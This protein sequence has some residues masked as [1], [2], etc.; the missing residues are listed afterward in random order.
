MGSLMRK[1]A[2]GAGTGLAIAGQMGFQAKLA[3]DLDSHRAEMMARRDAFLGVQ[4]DARLDKRIGAEQGEGVL[5]REH[6]TNLATVQGRSAAEVKRLDN[7]GDIAKLE[8]A[9][10]LKANEP[11]MADGVAYL[12]D[13][14][15]R[16]IPATK[17]GEEWTANADLGVLV[18][19]GTGKTKPVGDG[20]GGAGGTKA[21]EASMKR[22]TM[23]KDLAKS[24]MGV[25]FFQKLNDDERKQFDAIFVEAARNSRTMPNIEDAYEAAIEKWNKRK[26]RAGVTGDSKP[27]GNTDSILDRFGVPKAR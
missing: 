7:E 23:L 12:K 15:G 6:A 18:E 17:K 21:E 26:A 8:R 19:K 1:M 5:N 10:E 13:D 14:K 4:E 24:R 27:G 22:L 9:A 16:L 11:I 3:T 20:T 25:D 2:K